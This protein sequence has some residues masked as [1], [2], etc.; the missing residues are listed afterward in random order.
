VGNNIDLLIFLAVVGLSFVNWIAGQIKEKREIEKI[1]KKRAAQREAQSTVRGRVESASRPAEG[2]G[3]GVS[4]AEQ[5]RQKL[6]ELRAKQAQRQREQVEVLTGQKRAGAQAGP[7]RPSG[8]GT[9][10]GAGAGRRGA[11]A[12]G[13]SGAGSSSRR[14]IRPGRTARKSG[15][16]ESAPRAVAD[17]SAPA[18][19]AP[20]SKAFT[21]LSERSPDLKPVVQAGSVDWRRAIVLSEVLA[22]PVSMRPLD[23]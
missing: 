15:E 1:N 20:L 16:R 21:P 2:A 13:S 9:A 18:P 19:D 23:S 6:R 14:P 22:P 17:T 11:P 4:L 8:A 12:R 10:A 5:R 3:E 7:A